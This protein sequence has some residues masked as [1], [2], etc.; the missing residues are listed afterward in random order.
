MTREKLIVTKNL[1]D[2][3]EERALITET[4]KITMSVPLFI[5]MLEYAKEDAKTDMDLHKATERALAMKSNLDMDQYFAIIGEETIEEGMK[6]KKGASRGPIKPDIKTQADI[7]KE[8][9]ERMK[10]MKAALK[11]GEKVTFKKSGRW[12]SKRKRA[13]EKLKD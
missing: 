4:D 11:S 3:I 8:K 7:K 2:I 1:R 12:D 9:A 10:K 5:R 6:W 13:R